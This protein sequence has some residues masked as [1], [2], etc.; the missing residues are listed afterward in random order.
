MGV[1]EIWGEKTERRLWPHIQNQHLFQKGQEAEK[2]QSQRS[3]ESVTSL[4]PRAGRE[5]LFGH[6]P[7]EVRRN[8]RR[9][10]L[11]KVKSNYWCISK[12]D[13]TGMKARGLERGRVVRRHD[14]HPQRCPNH[15]K[16]R[17][18]NHNRQLSDSTPLLTTAQLNMHDSYQLFFFFFFVTHQHIIQIYAW[19][20]DCKAPSE[21][22]TS[23]KLYFCMV[24]LKN[25]IRIFC[26][27]LLT[28][29]HFYYGSYFIVLIAGHLV[30]KICCC[31]LFVCLF[32]LAHLCSFIKSDSFVMEH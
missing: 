2:G 24:F 30:E 12:N 19:F 31:L 18:D 29:T 15:Q 5:F 9:W 14:L 28:S 13:F 6:R 3:E 1:I 26:H 25:L 16:G 20:Q 22:Q 4:K 8:E 32:V 7:M 11:A 23:D 27:I 10:I 17:Q 21:S